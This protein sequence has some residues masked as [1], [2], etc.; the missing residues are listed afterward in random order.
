[1]LHCICAEFGSNDAIGRVCHRLLDLR[2]R[3]GRALADGRVRVE[4]PF[5]Q[6][7]LANWAG[8]SREAVV[9]GL[10]SLR[11]LG[12]IESDGRSITVID[13]TALVTRAAQ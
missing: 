11:S 1:M 12:W 6:T 13:E 4:L 3:Y 5:S 7:D 9:K 2:P 10:R 8:L